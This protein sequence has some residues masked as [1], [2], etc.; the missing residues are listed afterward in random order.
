MFVRIELSR[1]RIEERSRR[2][3]VHTSKVPEYVAIDF[4]HGIVI[5]R[6]HDTRATPRVARTHAITMRRIRVKDVPSVF[7]PATS[8]E[9][10]N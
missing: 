6:C 10:Q 3:R 5:P 8:A 7:R 1:N 9:A 2:Y 4:G